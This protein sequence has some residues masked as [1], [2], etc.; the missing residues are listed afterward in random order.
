MSVPTAHLPTIIIV[1]GIFHVAWHM[2]LLVT[3]LCTLGF[4]TQV[5]DLPTVNA[6][7]EPDCYERDVATIKTAIANQVNA[8]KDVILLMHSY[9]GIPG[10]EAACGFGT[11]TANTG[12]PQGVVRKLIYLTALMFKEDTNI[13]SVPYPW[14][15]VAKPDE[16]VYPHH[17]TTHQ[18][19]LLP[20]I[21]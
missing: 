4:E 5:L 12:K 21:N 9:G 10:T 19:S 8:N 11:S 18:A 1:P 2:N 20:V 7:P 16:Q 15:I 6:S 17:P 3:E 13:L 14:P